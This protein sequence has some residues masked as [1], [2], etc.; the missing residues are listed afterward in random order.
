MGIRPPHCYL[1]D[2]VQ[3]GDCAVAADFDPTPNHRADAQDKNM[4]LV[5]DK[6]LRI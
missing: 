5:D 1:D 3:I 6:F 2:V 4:K